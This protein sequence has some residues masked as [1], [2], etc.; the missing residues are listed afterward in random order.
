MTNECERCQRPQG[1]GSTVCVECTKP[2]AKLLDQV[3]RVAGEA[4]TTIARLDVLGDAGGASPEPEID[5]APKSPYALTATALPVDLDAAEANRT[6][7]RELALLARTV[8]WQ[9]GAAL[10]TVHTH[11]V[12][13][14]H[15]TCRTAR[16]VR[17]R[18]LG[19]ACSVPVQ[20]THPLALVARWLSGQLGWL[21]HQMDADR[22]LSGI[23]AACRAILAV[24]DRKPARWSLGPCGAALEPIVLIC[25]EDLRPISGA[26]TVWC[27]CGAE[28][29]VE[30]RKRELL[31]RLDDTWLPA[32]KA[33]HMLRWL[34][35]EQAN[36]NTIRG[37]AKKDWL[38]AHPSSLPGQPA[39][40]LGSIRELIRIERN[41]KLA[42]AVREAELAEAA[43]QRKQPQEATA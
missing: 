42:Y 8:A 13:C 27:K 17:G 25:V 31:D 21:R 18:T 10:P 39:Y 22:A 23:E 2:V 33:T 29:D 12:A 36:A 7:V 38:M 5:P 11:Q 14:G 4:T 30:A 24:V 34:G 32:T 40:R 43:R 41:R 16:A 6:A 9:R 37:W 19:P 1:D 28:W 3:V 35:E 26:R 15:A 20:A